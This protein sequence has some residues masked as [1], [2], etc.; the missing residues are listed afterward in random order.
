MAD[1]W[2]NPPGSEESTAPHGPGVYRRLWSLAGHYRFH[3]FGILILSLLATPIALLVPLPLKLAFDNVLG[4]EPLPGAIDAVL[5]GTGLPSGSGLILFVAGSVLVIA[6]LTQLQVF[7]SYL[8]LFYVGEKLVMTFQSELFAHVQRLSMSFHDERG[9]SDSLYRIQYDAREIK[10]IIG[11]IPLMGSLV[12]V[13]GMIVVSATIDWQLSLIALAF[14]PVLFYFLRLYRR[15]TGERWHAAK[16]LQSSAVSVVQETLGAL[17]VVKAFGQE[18]REKA[19]FVRHSRESLKAM[20][21]LAWAEGNFAWLLRMTVAVG[22]ASVL[23]IGIT[24][25]RSGLLTAGE[26]LVVMGYLTMLYDPLEAM[27]QKIATLQSSIASVERA[28]HLLD[29]VPEVRERPDARP[30]ERATG[31]ILF[32]EV[33]FAYSDNPPIF[34]EV[35]FEIAFGRSVGITGPTGSGKTTLVSLLTRFIDPTSGAIYLDGLDLRAYKLA[36]LRNQFAIVLQEPVLFS[37]TIADNISYARPDANLDEIMAAAEAAN[38]H[39]AIVTLPDGYETEVGERGMRLSGGER[40]RISLARAFL[41]DAPILILD[42]PTSSVDTKTETLI[43]DAMKRL[44]AGRTTLMIAHRTSTLDMCDEWLH[45]Q[46]RQVEH[47]FTAPP[48]S[49]IRLEEVSGITGHGAPASSSRELRMSG[50]GRR[51]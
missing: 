2:K 30:L 45:V 49:P 31:S 3:L 38:V 12:T 8:L 39:D 5:P 13:A 25:V 22:M 1:I 11:V 28:F 50:Q 17:R 47:R 23:L 43:M 37:A 36:D 4:S 32:D 51:R 24:H 42:E 34:E 48:S 20:F 19:R 15:H 33:G 41:K 9:T 6:V 29:E 40:Q 35:G 10:N 7:A 44:K 26:F 21:R 14:A 27:S 18:D 46:D 16:E